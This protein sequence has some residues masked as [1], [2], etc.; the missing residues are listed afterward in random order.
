MKE[1]L[2]AASSG[3]FKKNISSYIAVGVFSG[4]FLI[5]AATLSFVDTSLFILA[6]PLI[7]LPFIFASHVACYYLE[8]NQPITMSAIARYFFGFFSPQFRSSFRGIKA[9]LTSLAVYFGAMIFIYVVFYAIYKNIYGATFTDRFSNLVSLY[10][11]NEATYEDLLNE[12]NKNDGFLLTFFIYV[13]TMPLPFALMW[14]IYSTSFSSL[15]IYYR[16]NIKAGSAALVRLAINETYARCRNKM[17]KDWF[18]LNWP[19]LVLSLVGSVVGGLIAYFFIK[20]ILFFNALVSLGSVTLLIFF[21]PFYF[22]NMEAIYLRYEHYF[23][24]GNKAAVEAVLARIQN[25][26]ELSEEER[27]HLEE[28]F[29]DEEREGE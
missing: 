8:V 1:S 12:M 17:R 29:K 16:L 19:L 18:L 27:K 15:S 24:E 6:L 4:L 25:S 11:S 23:K 5:L 20:D 14:F 28:S 10:T 9:F 2:R 3:R 13:S 22:A 21:L 26:I 7:V